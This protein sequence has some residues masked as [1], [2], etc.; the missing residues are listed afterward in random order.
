MLHALSHIHNG[1]DVRD[2]RRC[3]LRPLGR[4]TALDFQAPHRIGPVYT[5]D[6]DQDGIE[7]FLCTALGRMLLN[8]RGGL[9]CC[10][11][12]EN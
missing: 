12:V 5:V 2:E 1:S 4:T 6:V 3:R 8:S 9:H 7:A 11:M 10:A